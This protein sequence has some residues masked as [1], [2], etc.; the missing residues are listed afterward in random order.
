MRAAGLARGGS[1]DNAVVIG[2][3][4][5]LNHDGLRFADE[6]VRHKVL[7]A[8]GD[9]YLAGVP[10]IGAFTACAR[11]TPSTGNCSRRCS[12]TA[13]PTGPCVCRPMPTTLDWQEEPERV[14]RVTFSA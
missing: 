1:L 4:R 6:F 11:A 2:G 3:G 14:R 9:L 10:I 8:L 7:D 12:P 5:V 13:P